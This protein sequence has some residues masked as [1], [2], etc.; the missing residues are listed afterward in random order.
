ME[1]DELIEQVR[2]SKKY[3]AVSPD[4]I[5][6]IG[7]R[8]LAAHKSLKEAVKATK[9]KLHQVAGAYL[10][11]RPPYQQW[12]ARLAAAAG[13]RPTTNDQRPTNTDR[14]LPRAASLRPA[15]LDLMRHHA[16]TRERLPI[17]DT[18]F[19]QALA[20]VAPV[21]SVLDVACGLNPLAIPW[22][23]LAEGAAYYACDLY[24]DMADFLNGFFELAGLRGQA[25]VCDLLGGPPDV[26]VDVALVLKAL[27]PLE[28]LERDAG[29]DLLRTLRAK[30]LLVSFPARSLGGRPKGMPEHYEARFRA[31][32]AA[33]GW[34]I[35]RF[36]F[37]TELA[38]LV[39]K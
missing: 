26:A 5:R 17:L 27:P 13:D 19:T 31:L 4:L 37:A 36:A 8:E 11:A 18:F 25:Q 1:I 28:Q 15:C 22:M 12:L 24:A 33:E 9:N 10:D 29:R 30:H 32:A 20:S 35:E 38:F 16:S 6:A 14:P 7:A 3:A 2:A 34:A 21:R 23:P 39:T